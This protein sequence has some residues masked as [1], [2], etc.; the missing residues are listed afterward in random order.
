M[1]QINDANLARGHVPIREGAPGESGQSP[2]INHGFGAKCQKQGGNGG[3]W[4]PILKALLRTFLV[5]WT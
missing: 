3:I 4:K 2:D 1:R 5:Q